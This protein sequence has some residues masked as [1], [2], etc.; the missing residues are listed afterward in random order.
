M[1]A[2]WDV[3]T[4]A[5]SGAWDMC[6]HGLPPDMLCASCEGI[7]T[8]DPDDTGHTTPDT[9]SAPTTSAK[10]PSM[11]TRL[12][13]H[14]LDHH[15]LGWA[16]DGSGP[17]AVAHGSHLALPLRGGRNSLRGTLARAAHDRFGITPSA[18]ALADALT[19][20][21]GYAQDARPAE[22]HL[23]AATR[24]G[25]IWL[26]LGDEDGR[27][28]RITADGWTVLDQAPVT[29]RRTELTGALPVPTRGGDLTELWQFANVRPDLRPLLAG[30]LVAVLLADRPCPVCALLGEQGTGKTTATRLL[31]SMLDPSPATTRKPPRDIEA[32]V[33]A[34]AGSR[35]V[36]VDNLSGIP[37]WFSDSLCRAV[38]GEADV[39]RT[40]YTDG[41][42]TVFAFRRAV[43][44]NGID[45]GAVRPDLGDRLLP[46]ALDRIADA[47]RLG[48]QDL[49]ALWAAAWPRVLGAVLDLAAAVLAD[50]AAHPRPERLPRMADYG[51]ILHALDRITGSDAVATYARLGDELAGD[52]VNLDPVLAALVAEVRAPFTGTA[53]DLL[54]RLDRHRPTPIPREWPRSARGIAGHLI[55]HAPA[56]RRL[57]WTVE[58]TLDRHTK[59]SAW[60]LLPPAVV[61]GGSAV[62][63]GG[64][65]VVGGGQEAQPPQPKPANPSTKP[66]NPPDS[67]VVAVVQPL[68][69]LLG[70]N[71]EVE[72][73]TPNRIT[74]GMTTAT[75]ATTATDPA[76]LG[77]CVNCG[78]TTHRYG[79]GGNPL[80]DRC[81]SAMPATPTAAPATLFETGAP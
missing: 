69:T 80:C 5:T 67:A 17:F 52:A 8:A 12:V 19:T 66:P 72:G 7:G 27:A 15:R 22:V 78:Q 35:V 42:L 4:G 1:T 11:A 77:P 68:P 49:P 51:R 63:G 56:L 46:I 3:P 62:V 25:A 10:G 59:N 31:G 29:F 57:G 6:D 55:R 36:A 34:A 71:G 26:D 2:A 21:E 79:D 75:T 33:T 43:L 54:D 37:E 76:S 40:L 20:L 48:E 9:A 23:R 60:R 47:D 61:G 16:V 64:S 14:A 39:R 24:D 44:V 38:T 30:W 13:G 32:W 81:R 74:G 53:G 45:L 70:L 41:G 28:V 50:L 18:T 65:A 73:T 58:R